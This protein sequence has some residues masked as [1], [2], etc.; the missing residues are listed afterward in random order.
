MV[1][2]RHD[3][4]RLA[5]ISVFVLTTID[6]ATAAQKIPLPPRRPPELGQSGPTTPAPVL[7]TP[8]I[9]EPAAVP[10]Q[11]TPALESLSRD[12]LILE[13]NNALT[14]LKQFS[15]KFSQID[16][17]GQTVTGQ[18]MVLRP[19]RLRFDYNPP[20]ALKIIADGNNVAVIDQRLGTKDLYSIGLTPLKFLLSR[21]IDLNREFKLGDIQIEQDRVSLEADDH[22][23][24]GGSSHIVLGFDRKSLLLKGW[25][26]TDPQGYSVTLKLTQIDTKREL[27]PMGF[28]IPDNVVPIK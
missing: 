11:S 7:I 18:L 4:R 2:M 26:V 13:I 24:F 12:E 28:I 22:A 17:S 16:Q 10:S 19:G 5:V 20:S 1:A 9:N 3:A 21:S 6:I 14:N 15:A 27:D 23:T 8:K 25:T